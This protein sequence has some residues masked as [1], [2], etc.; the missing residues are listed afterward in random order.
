[1]TQP[2]P[3]PPP[4][5]A[6]PPAPSAP[7]PGAPPGAAP[8]APVTYAPAAWPPGQLEANPEAKQLGM[9]AHLVALAG[10]IIPFGNIIGPLILWMV[11]KDQVPFVNDQGKES[12]NF[13]ITVTLAFIASIVAAVLLACAG[14]GVLFYAVWIIPIAG[15]VMAAM[16]A[17]EAN[18]GVAYRY[19]FA[20]RLIK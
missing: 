10:L 3:V 1:M 6:P 13:Q 2:E 20:L 5:P 14:V 16:A 8:P 19:P 18:K 4:P 9:F 12:L 17:M 11:K 15:A 7:P